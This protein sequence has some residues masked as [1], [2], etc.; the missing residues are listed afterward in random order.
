MFT[1]MWTVWDSYTIEHMYF[2]KRTEE[3]FY[4]LIGKIL[5]NTVSE[6]SK[7]P[8]HVSSAI[9]TDIKRASL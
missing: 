7:V 2:L 9:C 1:D 6:K 8:N 3:I 4:V 5:Q